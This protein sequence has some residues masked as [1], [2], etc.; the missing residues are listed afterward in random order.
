MNSSDIK[1][2]N[3]GRF[4]K[5]R[6]SVWV[7]IGQSRSSL[8]IWVQTAKSETALVRLGPGQTVC[9][10]LICSN[11]LKVKTMRRKARIANLWEDV[12]INRYMVTV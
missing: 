1:K 7:R 4:H 12:K 9:E 6:V 11:L 8:V 5:I 2:A 3:K 10:F